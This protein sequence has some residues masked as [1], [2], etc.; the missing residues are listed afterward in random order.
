METMPIAYT[1]RTGRTYYLHT[2]PKRGGGVQYYFSQKADGSLA[3]TAPAGFEIYESVGGQVFLRRKQPKL[4]RD[5]EKARV[6]REIER[7][8]SENLYKVEVRGK[9]LVIFES[10][11]G[12]GGLADF[13]PFQFVPKDP[14]ADRKLRERFASYLPV[15]RFI[16][17]DAELRLFAPERFCFRGSVDGWISIGPPEPLG[18]LISNTL[19]HLGRDSFYDLY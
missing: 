8:R 9:T 14:V 13:A 15:M 5:E 3:E 7:L 19:K 16:L 12:S 10:S 2:G 11:S 4:I 17:I 18:K 1:S 6:E